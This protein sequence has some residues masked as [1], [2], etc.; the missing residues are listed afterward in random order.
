MCIRLGG[1]PIG[2][3]PAPQQLPRLRRRQQVQGDR[4]GTLGRDQ[5]GELV[6]AGHQ[7]Q[8]PR[9]GREQRADLIRIPGVVQHDQHPPA[10]EQAPVEADLPREARRLAIGRHPQRLQESAS[11]SV[12]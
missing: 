4:M 8:A 2:A 6:A 9:R 3:E 11:G 10:G 7:R 1:Y 5:A 12:R